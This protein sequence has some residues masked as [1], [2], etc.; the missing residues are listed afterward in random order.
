[1]ELENPK[2]DN[3]LKVALVMEVGNSRETFDLAAEPK[4]IEFI[5]G[6]AACGITP[7]EKL[8]YH[9]NAGDEVIAAVN[10]KE[11]E[12]YF[13]PLSAGILSW[14][15]ERRELYF[16]FSIDAIS[17]PQDSE[18][19]KALASGVECGGDCDCGC[20]CGVG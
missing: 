18:V 15:P 12:A 13:G 16:K 4:K 17:K 20:G 1:M 3:L 2:L 10:L 6:T 5:Y 19:I 7:F 14:L 11:A 8:L 9:K